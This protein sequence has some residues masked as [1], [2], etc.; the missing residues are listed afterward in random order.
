[1]MPH[2]AQCFSMKNCKES[3]KHHGLL[4]NLRP[5][6]MDW[7]KVDKCSVFYLCFTK[8]ASFLELDLYYY[9]IEHFVAVFN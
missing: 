2:E 6:E 1:M 5:S 7:H 8:C 4:W 9:Y 3:M